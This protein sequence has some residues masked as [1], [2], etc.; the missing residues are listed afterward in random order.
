MKT[1]CQFCIPRVTQTDFII[2]LHENA[3][4]AVGLLFRGAARG[5]TLTYDTKLTTC[6]RLLHAKGVVREKT[7][8]TYDTKHRPQIYHFMQAAAHRKDLVK[9]SKQT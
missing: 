7:Y 1:Q 9:T 6:V 3:S 2:S 5:E 4:A 8:L